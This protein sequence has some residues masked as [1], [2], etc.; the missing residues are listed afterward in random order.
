VFV[1]ET[2]LRDSVSLRSVTIKGY[3]FVRNDRMVRSG[4]GVGGGVVGLYIKS[5][6]RFR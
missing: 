6:L 4:P 3:K 5:G 2:F 1:K